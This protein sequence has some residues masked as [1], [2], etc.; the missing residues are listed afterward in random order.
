MK[1]QSGVKKVFKNVPGFKGLVRS[2]LGQTRQV[3]QVSGCW[4]I[5]LRDGAKSDEGFVRDLE[6]TLEA[7]DSVSIARYVPELDR[8]LMFPES[9]PVP[10]QD[11]IDQLLTHVEKK[12]GWQMALFASRTRFP[13]DKAA[14][15]RVVLEMAMDSLSFGSGFVIGKVGRRTFNFFTDLGALTLLLESTP[16]LR[17]PMEK[18]LG[19]D[20][21]ELLFQA[22]SNVSDSFSQGWS[23]SLVDIFYRYRA[24]HAE[25]NREECWLAMRQQIL[26]TVKSSGPLPLAQL[27]R[28]AA[29]PDGPVEQYMSTAE[30]LSLASFSAGM[31][32]THSLNTSAAMLFASIPKP[33]L[34]GRDAYCQELV[35]Q[36]ARF[37]ILTL[38]ETPLSL[39][40]R[41]NRIVIDERLVKP[42]RKLITTILPLDASL[43]SLAELEKLLVSD[44]LTIDDDQYLMVQVRTRRSIPLKA[45]E[46]F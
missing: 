46:W 37:E 19:E 29:V 31:A 40:D 8:L 45:R 42:S 26:E 18:W 9:C 25:N 15:Q 16:E 24:W 6:R 2:L 17:A 35:R 33:A 21:T 36:F 10:D 32:L 34:R 22:V 1:L 38:N 12:H 44:S 20:N 7:L 11:E 5:E 30:K 28:P 43:P 13:E 23:G 39:L 27:A 3:S 4:L 41:V 14:R